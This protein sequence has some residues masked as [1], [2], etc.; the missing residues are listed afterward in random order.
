M[1]GLLGFLIVLAVAAALFVLP[2][3]AWLTQRDEL[4]ASKAELTQLEAANNRLAE[5]NAQLQTADGISQTARDDL[6]YQEATESVAAAL[7]P[8][9]I[10]AVLPPGWPNSL[11]GQI[12]AVRTVAALTAAS[13]P[14]TLAPATTIAGLDPQQVTP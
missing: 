5:E 9:E 11:V 14:T 3:R 10:A 4:A 7:P 13:A 6:G 1:F 8:P 12:L 2:M